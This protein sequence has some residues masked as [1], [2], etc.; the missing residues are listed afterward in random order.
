MSSFSVIDI[1]PCR[2][3][4]IVTAEYND[5]VF[6]PARGFQC[7]DDLANCVIH[8]GDVTKHCLLTITE[9]FTLAGIHISI[10]LVTSVRPMHVLKWDV[11]KEWLLL[12]RCALNEVHSGVSD[13]VSA[14]GVIHREVWLAIATVRG[15]ACFK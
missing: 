9:P 8:L 13:K 4:T 7:C 10:L 2:R 11:Q 14:V 12:L 6:K 5:G 15:R 3:S 1:N